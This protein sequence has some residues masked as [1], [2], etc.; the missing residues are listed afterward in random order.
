MKTLLFLLFGEV[1]LP[2]QNCQVN[3]PNYFSNRDIEIELFGVESLEIKVWDNWGRHIKSIDNLEEGLYSY[4]I[5]Y[6]CQDGT[7]KTK[8]GDIQLLKNNKH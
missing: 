6:L 2:T 3:V 4:Q 5:Y 7:S 8:E 1:I